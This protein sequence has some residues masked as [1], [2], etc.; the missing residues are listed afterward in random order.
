MIKLTIEEIEKLGN[1]FNYEIEI[2][3][4][5]PFKINIYLE[6]N[7]CITFYSEDQFVYWLM[8]IT[9]VREL[10]ATSADFLAF[11]LTK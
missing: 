2:V 6:N 7:C 1:E 4:N 9:T 3:S 11:H 5:S 8:G 10:R